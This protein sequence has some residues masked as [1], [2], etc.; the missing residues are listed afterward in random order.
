MGERYYDKMTAIAEAAKG[1]RSVNPILGRNLP[2]EID[3]EWVF[4]S[5]PSMKDV[6]YFAVEDVM[7][8]KIEVNKGRNA[9]YVELGDLCSNDEGVKAIQDAKAAIMKAINDMPDLPFAPVDQLH[10]ACN[11]LGLHSQEVTGRKKGFISHP[12]GGW[13]YSNLDKMNKNEIIDGFNNGTIDA[14]LLNVAGAT[15]FSFHASPKFADQ[16]TR[17]M[18]FLEHMPAH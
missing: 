3:G 8:F 7:R 14:V 2:Q 11:N 16:R 9:T 15:G 10:E 1:G 12:S 4:P 6:F 17:E 5:L 18:L 13:V